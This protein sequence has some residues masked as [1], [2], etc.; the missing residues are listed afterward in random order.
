VPVISNQKL[1]VSI[2]QMHNVVSTGPIDICKTPAPPAPAP[3][4]LPYP[5]VAMSATPGPGYT[6]KT[7][8]TATPSCTKK[9][10]ILLSN[11][12]QPGVAM[13]IISNR[14]MGMAAATAASSD[15]FLESGAAVRTLDSGESNLGSKGNVSAATF[16]LAPGVAAKLGVSEVEAYWICKLHCQAQKEY[17]NPKN[18]KVKGPGAISRRFD[19]L[20]AKAKKDVP[21][22]ANLH[23]E[24]S[25]LLLRGAAPQL[26][27]PSLFSSVSSAIAAT[28]S[29]AFNFISGFGGVAP[30]A[31]LSVGANAAV[32]MGKALS[33]MRL[34]STCRPD[35][36]STANGQT[37]VLDNKFKWNKGQDKF[38]PAQKRNYPKIDSKG[39]LRGVTGKKCGCP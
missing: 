31:G 15:V 20:M 9:S 36:I 32:R 30:A 39:K 24:Q 37:T 18:K 13:G 4:P 16:V 25:F 12:D 5:N 23:T 10:K 2:S 8:V 29:R 17:K 28:G 11:G 1:V 6:T 26:L 19:E 34:G 3:V 33:A 27:T 7:L 21:E 22:L 14:I 35:I 38:S